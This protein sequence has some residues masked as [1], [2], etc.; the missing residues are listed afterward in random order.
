M[1][2]TR[3]KHCE[4]YLL[5]YAGPASSKLMILAGEPDYEEVKNGRLLSGRAGDVLRVE[6][7]KVGLQLSALRY[8]TTWSHSPGECQQD[9]HVD[10]AM[11]EIKGKTN[12]LVMGSAAS[13]SLFDKNAIDLSGLTLTHLLFKGT[14]FTVSPGPAELFGDSLGEFYLAFERFKK[15]IKGGK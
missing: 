6:L 15:H 7:A 10:R 9:W 13:L 1:S 3:C 2:R 11:S 12:V 8:V 5:E 14:L 4:K